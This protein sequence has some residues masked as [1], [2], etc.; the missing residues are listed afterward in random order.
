M[1]GPKQRIALGALAVLAIGAIGWVIWDGLS[2]ANTAGEGAIDFKVL[3]ANPQCQYFADA[4]TSS[5]HTKSGGRPARVPSGGPGYI[6]PKCGQE[7]LYSNP[8][9]CSACQTPYLPTE[10]DFRMMRGTCPKCKKVQ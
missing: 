10:S 2:S 5:L 6:C 3:C 4:N 7:T 8:Y 1:S 9:V